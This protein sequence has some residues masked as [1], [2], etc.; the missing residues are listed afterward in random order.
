MVQETSSESLVKTECTFV[1][2]FGCSYSLQNATHDEGQLA[3]LY[4]K[5]Q[6]L[7]NKSLCQSQQHTLKLSNI[8]LYFSWFCSSSPNNTPLISN[9]RVQHKCNATSNHMLRNTSRIH[10]IV[11]QT[12]Y[13]S[14]T[15]HSFGN[16]LYG[17]DQTLMSEKA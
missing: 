11:W 3:I 1:L 9:T 17:L 8:I 15:F 2:N 4:Q 10:E 12:K 13:H 16:G 6:N 7:V 5:I 14:T